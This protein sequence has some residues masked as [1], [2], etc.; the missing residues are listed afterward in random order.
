MA[1][2]LSPLDVVIIIVYMGIV[3]ALG[4]VMKRR[5]QKSLGSYFLGERQLPWW[6]LAMSGSLPAPKK[7]RMMKRITM[8]SVGP[9]PPNIGSCPPFSP[10]SV[11]HGK[12]L[13]GGEQALKT[14]VVF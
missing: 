7:M 4:V 1:L 2:T 14:R 5:A 3:I 10:R 8:S 11:L 13:P 6:A 12:P 9:I